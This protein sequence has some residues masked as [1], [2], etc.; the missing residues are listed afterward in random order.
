MTKNDRLF[1]DF[2]KSQCKYYGV[3]CDLRPTKSVTI[4]PKQKASGY[5]DEANR[6][7]V[8]AMK[9]RGS[10]GVLVHEYC[11]LTQWAEQADVWMNGTKS[12]EIMNG[13][14]DR[15]GKGVSDIEEHIARARD[16][17]LDNEKRS[18]KLIKDY[19]LGI[20]VKMYV[21]KANAYIQFY[22][23]LPI[24]KRWCKP[25]NTPY[26]NRKIVAAMP[27]KFSMNYEKISPKV[28]KLFKEEN[29]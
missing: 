24:S 18:A 26:N 25:K 4:G 28:L 10:L 6:E 20:D 16:I 14:L 22:N 17:E 15:G 29:I 9:C 21:K 19:G 12:Y 8:V 13:W 11:H 7:L 1:I 5:F 27:D 2:V 23:Y 3:K